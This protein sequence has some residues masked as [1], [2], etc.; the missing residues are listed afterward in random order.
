MKLSCSLIVLSVAI[1][2]GIS[3]P[4][5]AQSQDYA[6]L[7]AL[8]DSALTNELT[9]RYDAGLSASLDEGYISADD[10]RYLWALETKV[11][12]AI[13]LGFMESS[14]R[15]E[16][17]IRNCGRAYD[18]MNEVPMA[19]PVNITP[20]PQPP[21]PPQRRL[22][23]CADDVIGMVFFDFDEAE[24]RDDA[25][26]TLD[27]VAQNVTACGW[28]AIDVVGHTD[29]AGSDAYNLSLSQ[30]R[31]NA[32]AAALRSRNLGGVQIEVSAQG[33]SNPRVPLAD[34][35]RSPQNR[36][37]EISAE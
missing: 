2:G 31:A 10:P 29:Q 20:A 14:T 8:G 28:S 15:D 32:V 12:C 4:A 5:S 36:R 18:R 22:E 30:E 34:G 24:V 25:A 35:T 33:E 23:Q 1:A 13:A 11:Q 9:M 26:S 6:E 16:T 37:V 3:L 19:P 17:S 21:Q 7:M 27:T